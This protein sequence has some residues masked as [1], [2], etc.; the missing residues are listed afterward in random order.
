MLVAAPAPIVHTDRSCYLV[1]QQVGVT[2]SGFAPDRAFTVTID[3]VSFGQNTTNA[4]GGFSSSLVPGGLGAGIPQHVDHLLASDGS[5]KAG[6]NFTLTRPPGAR[7]LASSGNPL[8]LRAPFQMWDFGSGHTVYLHYVSPSGN[9]RQTVKLGTAGGQ[10]GYLTT[11]KRRVFP[12]APS[13]GR[14][15][16][17]IDTRHGY[18]AHPA[19]PVARIHV[20]IS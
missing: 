8:T 3:G 9:L 1:G 4:S 10:C 18:A 16:F 2:G 14:W 5:Q 13:K 15:T 17:Q 20:K 7:F 19:A 11:H 6:T 12:F